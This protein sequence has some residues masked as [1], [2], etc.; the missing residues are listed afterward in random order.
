VPFRK[1]QASPRGPDEPRDRRR[2]IRK[3]RLL[4]LLA[5]LVV[6][7]GA[8]FTYGLVSAIASELPALDPTRLQDEEVNG[9]IYDSNTRSP[10]VL[11]VLRGSESRALVGPDAIAPIMKHAVV[12]TEDRRFYEHR[13][14]DIRGIARAGWADIRHQRTAQGGSTITQQ[15]V[16]NALVTQRKT[17]AR[18]LR[19]AALSWQLEQRWPKERILTAY[20]NTIYFGNGAYGVQQAA[21]TYFHHGAAKLTLPEAAL[22]AGIPADPTRFDPVTHPQQARRRRAV[23]LGL[24]RDQGFIAE[25]EYAAARTAPLPKPSSVRL[26]GT[27]GPAPYFVNY[28]KQQLVDKYGSGKVFGGGLRVTTTIDLELQRLAR[29]AIQKWLTTEDGPQAALVAVRP[30][31]G[32]VLA[33]FGGNNFRESQFNLAVQATRQPGSSFKPFVLS[34]ALEQGIA[35]ST[36]FRS[37]PTTISLGDKVWSVANYEDEYLG[38][39]DLED[40]TIHSDNAV[41]AQLTRL[42]GPRAVASQ[43]HKLGVRS[44]LDDY[45]AIGLGAEAVNPLE[46]ARAYATFANDGRRIDG[47]VF[48][49]RP[50]AIVRVSGRSVGDVNRPRPKPAVSPNTA[51]IVTRYLEEVVT[52][53]TGK[54]A[55]L[56]RWPAAGK[57]GT[58]ENYGDA[59][60]VGYTKDLAVAVWVGYPDTLKPMLT[61]FQGGPVAGGSYP[62]LIWKSFMEKALPYTQAEP[63]AFPSPVFPYASPKRVVMRN[64]K[65]GLDN[66]YCSES[67]TV[68]YFEGKGPQKEA[69]CK[70]NEVEVPQ[71]V[72]A[73]LAEAQARLAAQPLESALVYKPA[74]PGQRLG[75][76]LDQFPR[77]GSLS[78]Y[79]TVTLVLAKSLHGSVP[80]VVGLSL[81][82]ARDLLRR[83]GLEVGVAPSPYGRRGEVQAQ[84][85]AAGVAAA[86]GMRVKL[87]VARG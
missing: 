55:Y 50:R 64:G 54:R 15:F 16:K 33:M 53:G 48:G 70:Q 72:G 61:D 2:R 65:W 75:V 32:A 47:G 31:D 69:D 76:V 38:T 3:P 34:A 67:F 12:A 58:T 24:L 30:S 78:S 56:G 25:R 18:K 86:P 41:Y 29:E 84:E 6:L 43:A 63:E 21:L 1:R 80:R 20:L 40:A 49:D 37:E 59:W 79:D 62:A 19:E 60:F 7:S 66:G 87:V 26:P 22:L 45:F 39:I 5:A 81:A 42:V 14:I 4:A 57:T 77:R 82:D 35:P 51:R 52:Q 46:M 28:V 17:I 10:R 71:V 85:P 9:Y 74:R 68:L 36:T 73:S 11:A 13:G 27:Q 44:P 83:R 23:V 8:S